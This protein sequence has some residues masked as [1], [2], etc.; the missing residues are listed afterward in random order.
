MTPEQKM[1]DTARSY[2]SVYLKRGK[3]VKESCGVCG[4]PDSQMHHPD[5]S[6]PTEVVWLC[7]DHHK[8]THGG[9]FHV[10]RAIN[11]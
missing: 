7:R 9:T 10:K 6:K 1:R 11:N 3:L 4:S 2:A 5:Y 8:T